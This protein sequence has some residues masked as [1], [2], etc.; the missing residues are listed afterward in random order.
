MPPTYS[1]SVRQ[2]ALANAIKSVRIQCQLRRQYVAEK[3]KLSVSAI[4]KIEQ[5]KVAI[6]PLDAMMICEISGTNLSTLEE[7]YNLELSKL[8]P[9]PPPR[10]IR[11]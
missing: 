8:T 5:G 6:R 4:D 1:K 3:L 2:K 10:L 11:R 9:A 7:L